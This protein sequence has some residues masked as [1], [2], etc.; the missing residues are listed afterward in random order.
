LF[1][2][3]GSYNNNFAGSRRR[4]RMREVQHHLSLELEPLQGGLD[5]PKWFLVEQGGFN[6]GLLNTH[7]RPMPY[8]LIEWFAACATPLVLERPFVLPNPEQESALNR[9][10]SGSESCDLGIG[11]LWPLLGGS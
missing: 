3:V 4:W 9:V 10:P 2:F 11:Q 7:I 1:G 8:G 5:A 6:A